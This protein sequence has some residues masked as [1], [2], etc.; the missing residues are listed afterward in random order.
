MASDESPP[1]RPLPPASEDSQQWAI[2]RRIDDVFTKLGEKYGNLTGRVVAQMKPET[3]FAQ[4]GGL[5]EAKAIVRSFGTALTDPELYRKWGIRPPKGV[6]LYGPPGT[7]KTMLARALATET[8][9]VFYHLKLMNLTSKFGPN[10]GE[11][12][13]EIL[14][15]AKDQGRGVVFLDEANALSLEHLLP[16]AQAREAA[17]RLGAALCEKLDGLED[18]SRLLVVGSTIRPDSVDSSLVAPR[19]LDRLVEVPLPDGAS[20]QEILELARR[21]A[22]TAAGRTLFADIDYRSVLPPMGGMSGAEI[23]E[24]LGRALEQ[25]VHAAGEGRDA[26]LVT[27]HDLL[28][29]IDGYRRI[30]EMVEKIRYGQYL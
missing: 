5:R 29:Q 20:Q 7:G 28:Q 19:R 25:K 24:I 1:S 14:S 23:S 10:T 26:G 27:T 17:A 12:L 15:V 22:E 8:A 6:L 21:R 2:Q 16:P 3:T 11:L 30:R 9:A 18:F 13:P 4:I